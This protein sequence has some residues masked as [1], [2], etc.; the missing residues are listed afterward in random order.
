MVGPLANP[1]HEKFAQALAKGKSQGDAYAFAGYKPSYSNASTLR[2]NQKVVDRVAEL[3]HKA[4]DKVVFTI[5]DMVAQL[6]EDRAFA[7]ECITPAAAVSASMGKAKV[8]GMLTE[9]IDHNIT[10]GKSF[11]DLYADDVGEG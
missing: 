2:T 10:V 7:R 9:K 8:L 11:A 5:V 1:K 4:A 3:Q 6:D